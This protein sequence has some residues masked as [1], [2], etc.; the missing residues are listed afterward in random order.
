MA[1]RRVSDLYGLALDQGSLDFV[2]VD[3]DHDNDVYID[4]SAVRRLDTRWGRECGALIQDFFDTLQDAM[5]RGDRDRALRLLTQLQEPNETHLGVSSGRP[6]GHGLGRGTLAREFHDGLIAGGL[7]DLFE[8]FEEIAL[9][10]T[11]IDRDIL[12]DIT[13]NII[14]E[15]LIHYTQ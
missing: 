1:P 11:G 15:P 10:T 12:S 14:R 8:E 2:N 4:P 5:R 7:Y 9:L 6:A 3:V 13:T